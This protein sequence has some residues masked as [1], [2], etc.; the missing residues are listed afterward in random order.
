MEAANPVTMDVMKEALCSHD[1]PDGNVCWHD[2]LEFTVASLV[3]ELSDRPV[4]QI[5]LG[6]PCVNEYARLTF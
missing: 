4:M 1:S 3:M 2:Q 6:P 5:S